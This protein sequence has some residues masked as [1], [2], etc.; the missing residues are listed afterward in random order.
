MR[1]SLNT[2]IQRS[3]RHP[4][5]PSSSSSRQQS[6]DRLLSNERDD[7]RRSGYRDPRGNPL[8]V[9]RDATRGPSWI[10]AGMLRRMLNIEETAM[11]GDI[12]EARTFA[13]TFP[14]TASQYTRFNGAFC[15]SVFQDWFSD[16]ASSTL[17]VHGD[18]GRENRTFSALSSYSYTL[19]SWMR[20]TNFALPLFFFCGRHTEED[21]PLN[22]IAGIYRGLLQQLLNYYPDFPGIKNVPDEVIQGI[23]DG[24]R[25]RLCDIFFN[26]MTVIGEG[27]GMVTIIVDGAHFLE[28]TE[29][30][31]ERFEWFIEKMQDLKDELEKKES[32]CI[33]KLLLIFPNDSEWA[34]QW[35]PSENVLKVAGYDCYPACTDHQR[36]LDKVN[37]LENDPVRGGRPAQLGGLVSYGSGPVHAAG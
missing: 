33:I 15:S 28:S 34:H 35:V 32:N 4:E 12:A 9:P 29:D 22:G 27:G 11:G 6:S 37:S 3:E 14:I 16:H 26:V 13:R 8:D 5:P 18:E 7:R 31:A 19:L 17:I 20:M 1:R 21:D 30:D 36:L 10:S 2:S 24:S 23:E 25:R